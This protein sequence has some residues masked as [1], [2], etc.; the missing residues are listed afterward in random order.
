LIVGD[1]Q[2][3][4]TPAHLAGVGF[5]EDACVPSLVLG[6]RTPNL[7]LLP[8]WEKGVAHRGRF[9]GKPLRAISHF[10]HQ[11]AQP[12]P[13]PRVGE[14]DRGE[15]GAN[16]RGNAANH[17]SHPRT[18]P[19]S[20]DVRVPRR[21]GNARRGWAGGWDACAPYKDRSFGKRLHSLARFGLQDAQPP[22]SPRVGE[23]GWGEE[24]QPRTG[25][26]QTGY[27]TQERSP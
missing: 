7:P 16:A 23:G 8:V 22:P 11:D 6:F 19:L 17:V 15:E 9:F 20:G 26:P 10:S 21:W 24:G 4:G 25:M 13:S 5:L 12:P 1:G 18:L 3:G 2:A 27:R 14:G